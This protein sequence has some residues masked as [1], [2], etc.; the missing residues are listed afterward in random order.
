MRAKTGRIKC[1]LFPWEPGLVGL[2][3]SSFRGSYRFIS[4]LRFDEQ[5][6]LP[7][8]WIYFTAFSAVTLMQ[9]LFP[10]SIQSVHSTY[11]SKATPRKIFTFSIRAV[12]VFILLLFNFVLFD[13][14]LSPFQHNAMLHQWLRCCCPSSWWPTFCPFDRRVL[15]SAPLAKL[16]TYGPFPRWQII[17]LL[18]RFGT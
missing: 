5:L 4:S 17:L 3:T 8:G 13:N 10:L 18:A 11:L 1:K 16:L 15:W 2:S 7:R 14:Y 9:S 6:S 12:A